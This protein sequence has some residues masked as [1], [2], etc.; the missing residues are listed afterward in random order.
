MTSMMI[1]PDVTA[2]R[3]EREVIKWIKE[4]ILETSTKRKAR[5]SPTHQCLER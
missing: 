4:D 5:P 2:T 3:P 1:M